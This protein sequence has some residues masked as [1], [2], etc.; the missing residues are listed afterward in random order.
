MK[1]RIRSEYL[2][3]MATTSNGKNFPC[4]K[5]EYDLPFICILFLIFFNPS[6]FRSSFFALTQRSLALPT[7][8]FFFPRL[9]FA[10]ISERRQ[11]TCQWRPE[12][13]PLRLYVRHYL[14][15]LHVAH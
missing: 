13:S 3:S 14:A 7:D 8:T 5:N 11:Q 15:T 6:P 9:H 1:K 10:V 2:K 12:Q 4:G